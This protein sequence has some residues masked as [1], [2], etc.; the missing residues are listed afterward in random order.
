MGLHLEKALDYVYDDDFKNAIEECEIGILNS[1]FDCALELGIIY[2][3][4]LDEINIKKAIDSFQIGAVN[5]HKECQKELGEILLNNQKFKNYPMAIKWLLSSGYYEKSINVD[6]LIKAIKIM[7]K[8]TNLNSIE[9]LKSTIG[10]FNEYIGLTENKKILTPVYTY[11]N[12]LVCICGKLVV[13]GSKTIY[14]LNE[15]YNYFLKYEDK[16]FFYDILNYFGT[17]EVNLFLESCNDVYESEK[18]LLSLDNKNYEYDIQSRGLIYL[19]LARSYW[20]GLNNATKDINLSIKYY[21]N[22]K[23][24]IANSELEK[25]MLYYCKDLIRFGDYDSIRK[26]LKYIKSYSDSSEICKLIEEEI[27]KLIE[28]YDKKIY[29]EKIYFNASTGDVGAMLELAKLYENGSGTSI[30]HRK[31]LT[32]HQELYKKHKSKESFDYMFDYYRMNDKK[33]DLIILLKDAK[34]YNLRFSAQQ[35][36]T[37]RLLLASYATNSYDFVYTKGLTSI[38]I[39]S[40]IIYYM[41]DYYKKWWVE[42]YPNNQFYKDNFFSFIAIKKRNYNPYINKLKFPGSLFNFFGLFKGDWII[43]SVPGHEKTTNISNGISDIVNLVYLKNNFILKNTLIQRAYTV[44]KKATAS[45]GRSNDY[46]IDIKS[47]TIEYGFNAE[48]KNIIVIDDITTTG[49]TLIA[50]KNLL[51]NAGAEHVVLAALGKTKEPEYGY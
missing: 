16:E 17:K 12:D 35:D 39:E 31:A 50:C 5:G 6:G 22:A 25:I 1:D 32:I 13:K 46:R 30:D 47:L 8:N 24:S 18:Y 9:D 40:N 33:I 4:L 51:M 7:H 14:E 20:S 23:S 37:Y 15:N 10:I 49:S 29:F 2:S 48:G 43:C 19:W 44:D 11:R 38:D 42:N 41:F 36:E 28:E 26:Y 21:I 34:K 27:Y 45:F 3:E